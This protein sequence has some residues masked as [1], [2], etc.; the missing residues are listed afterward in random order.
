MKLFYRLNYNNES[1]KDTNVLIFNLKHNNNNGV[2][3]NNSKPSHRATFE[4]GDDLGAQRH[5]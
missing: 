1:A 2:E 4:V 3:R 5:R